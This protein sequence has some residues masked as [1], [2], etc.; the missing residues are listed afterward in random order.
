MIRL[1]AQGILKN[2]QGVQTPHL[3]VCL[4][5]IVLI[6]IVVGSLSSGAVDL[7]SQQIVQGL[8]RRGDPMV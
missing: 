1:S 5:G 7:T 3:G 2:W 8:L 6:V 4:M